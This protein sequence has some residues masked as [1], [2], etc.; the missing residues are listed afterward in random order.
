[1][2][3]GKKTKCL[4]AVPINANTQLAIGKNMNNAAIRHKPHSHSPIPA[5]IP[6]LVSFET[7]LSKAL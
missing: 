6:L 1:M 3:A 4:P 7:F 2:N 5:I